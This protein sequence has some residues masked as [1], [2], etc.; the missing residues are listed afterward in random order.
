MRHRLRAIVWKDLREILR[1]RQVWLPMLILPLMMTAFMPT[2][3]YL[4]LEKSA[5]PM[6]DLQPLMKFL[7][8]NLTVVPDQ[9]KLF[10]LAVNFMFPPLF[11][12]IPLMA[13]SIIGASCLVGERERKTLETLLYTPISLQEL[14]WGK[15]LAT[16]IPSYAVTLLSFLLFATLVNLGA[17]RLG[18]D[19][20]FPNAHWMVLIGLVSPATILFGLSGM[21]VISA[22]ASTFQAAQQLSG[23]IVLP[24][25]GLM[26]AQTTGTVVLQTQGFFLLAPALL[27][28]DV[29]L[30]WFCARRL[31][32]ERLLE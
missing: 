3:F 6:R 20:F 15:L 14:L 17:G 18:M 30:L 31:S 11:L 32:Y 13:G 24:F 12:M 21:V 9:Q 25:I 4:G 23:F 16:F 29:L 2:M 28:L 19:M 22:Y 26:V 1:N 7:P 10:F 27:L 8:T 5:K